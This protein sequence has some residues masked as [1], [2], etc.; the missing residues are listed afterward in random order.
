MKIVNYVLLN[1]YP[2][3]HQ[4]IYVCLANQIEEANHYVNALLAITM[5][6]KVKNVKCVIINVLLV[7]KNLNV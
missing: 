4:Q 5:I 1:A 3:S 2:V 6:L 7:Q